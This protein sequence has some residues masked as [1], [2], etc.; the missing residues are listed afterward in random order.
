[1]MASRGLRILGS[2]TLL[3]LIVC[4]PIQQ[5]AFMTHCFR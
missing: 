3:T 2:G 4:L 5:T 1:M